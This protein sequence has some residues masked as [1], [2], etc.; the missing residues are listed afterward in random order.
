MRVARMAAHGMNPN[1][2]DRQEMHR[3]SSE[4]VAAFNEGL[5]AMAAQALKVQQMWWQQWFQ[6]LMSPM[7]LTHFTKPATLFS[8]PGTSAGARAYR[9][10]DS[11]TKGMAQVAA[12]GLA[13]VSRTVA[14]NV[15]RLNKRRR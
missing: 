15:K 2:S 14:S 10:A 1:A 9:M 13:P 11:V 3:M 5:T 4:K 8:N 12:V 6:I 7:S